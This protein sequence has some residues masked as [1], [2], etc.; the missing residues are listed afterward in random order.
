VH[1]VVV[2]VVGAVSDSTCD[3]VSGRPLMTVAVFAFAMAKPSDV[4]T[5]VLAVAQQLFEN[6]ESWQILHLEVRAF[7]V[8]LRRGNVPDHVLSLP[9]AMSISPAVRTP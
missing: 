4:T 8:G 5:S 2:V 3:I 1:I 7:M 6:V 9:V